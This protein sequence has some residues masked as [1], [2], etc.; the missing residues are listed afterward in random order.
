MENRGGYAYGI[1]LLL[2]P[3]EFVPFHI[4]HQFH[5]TLMSKINC[6]RKASDIFYK[7]NNEFLEILPKNINVRKAHISKFIGKPLCAL[8]WKLNIDNWLEIQEKLKEIYPN[9]DIP[10]EPHISLEY[11][12]GSNFEV[13]DRYFRNLSFTTD[14]ILV[15]MNDSNPKNWK[16]II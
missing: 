8:G 12:R 10:D 7:I 2:T 16:K 9:A 15:D 13:C 11:F 6:K 4:E 3:N 1:W 5:I 14:I